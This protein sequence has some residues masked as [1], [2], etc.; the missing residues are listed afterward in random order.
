MNGGCAPRTLI[1]DSGL[2]RSSRRIASAT[3]FQVVDEIPLG[4]ARPVKQRFIEMRQLYAI[5]LW[6]GHGTRIHGSG[7]KHYCVTGTKQREEPDHGVQR[8]A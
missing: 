1:T 5:P 8:L 6:R 7:R 3:A 2:P 4:R